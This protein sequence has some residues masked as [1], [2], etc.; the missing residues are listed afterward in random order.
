MSKNPTIVTDSIIDSEGKHIS[1]S[2][3]IFPM[4]IR[5]YAWFEKLNS[6]FIN[7]DVKFD[8]NG[9][10]PS[11]YIMTRTAN[12]L[13]QYGTNDIEKLISDSFDWAEDL[14][15]NDV[16]EMISAVTKQMSQ[17]N[18]A[19]PDAAVDDKKKAQ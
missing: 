7:P 1:D 5:R 6:P 12:E 14:S 19:A 18:K 2:I 4:T 9:I 11:V 16:P 10:I 13:K 8:I 15:L 17:I 3:K